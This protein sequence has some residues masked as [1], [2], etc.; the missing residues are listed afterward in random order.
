MEDPVGRRGETVHFR[1]HLILLLNLS[2]VRLMTFRRPVRVKP[3]PHSPV[4][5]QHPHNTCNTQIPEALKASSPEAPYSFELLPSHLVADILS[6]ANDGSDR[7]VGLV[8]NSNATQDSSCNS[9]CPSAPT[10]ALYHV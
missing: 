8:P 3:I 9:R 4:A 1:H 2:A 6:L 5:A 7:K 10:A